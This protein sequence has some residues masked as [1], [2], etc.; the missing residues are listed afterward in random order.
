[1]TE[2]ALNLALQLALKL[3]M[4]HDEHEN[5]KQGVLRDTLVEV[6]GTQILFLSIRLKNL[7]YSHE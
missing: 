3:A 7:V 6:W 2:S 5:V 1:M 4:R